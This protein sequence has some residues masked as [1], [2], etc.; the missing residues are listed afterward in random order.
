[1]CLSLVLYYIVN[2]NI[3]VSSNKYGAMDLCL[4]LKLCRSY[5]KTLITS[6]FL[7]ISE[8]SQ[9][10][11]KNAFK[12]IQS[13][14][15]IFACNHALKESL[16]NMHPRFQ[17]IPCFVSLTISK[18]ES[19]FATGKMVGISNIYRKNLKF[20]LFCIHVS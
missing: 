11:I 10:L 3:L 16:R 4:I 15:Y 6:L 20:F 5:C 13:V 2:I 9:K 8:F 18:I 14:T 17:E 12:F 1:M 7:K 19:K